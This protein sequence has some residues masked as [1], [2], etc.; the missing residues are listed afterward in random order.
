MCDCVFAE[1]QQCCWRGVC[2][3]MQLCQCRLYSAVHTSCVVWPAKVSCC[4]TQICAHKRSRACVPLCLRRK[5][6]VLLARVIV[7]SLGA[8]TTKVESRERRTRAHS[9]PTSR[10]GASRHPLVSCAC[11]WNGAGAG[12]PPPRADVGPGPGA[13]AFVSTGAHLMHKLILMLIDRAHPLPPALKS[14]QVRIPMI[15][16]S[17]CITLPSLRHPMYFERH[18]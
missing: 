4:P 1:R 8:T 18:W 14:S 7:V 9:G 5:T 11:C 16:S 10:L 2:C 17:H 13:N 6:A 3:S 12:G 15:D